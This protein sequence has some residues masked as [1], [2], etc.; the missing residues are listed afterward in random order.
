[1]ESVN[2]A[3]PAARA[4]RPILEE[5]LHRAHA[6]Y[7]RD[8]PLSLLS[9]KEACKYMPGGNT[10]TVLY[11]NPFP[12]SFS[13]GFGCL[14][15]TLDGQQYI[16]FLGDFSAGIYGHSHP[17]IRK[18]IDDALDRGWNMGGHNQLEHELAQVLC[19]RFPPLQMV[20]FVNSG[21]EAVMISI[22]T[23]IAF[24]KR[25]KVLL[26]HKGYRGSTIS[27]RF[28][29]GRQSINLPHEFVLAPY[30]D[31]V[32][33]K[34][35]IEDLPPDSL[36]AIVVEPMLGSGGCFVGKE[37]F[38]KY[39]R[40][41]SSKLGALLIFDEVMTS[42]LFYFD[43]GLTRPI[44]PD[45]MT[46]GEWVGG[47][48]PF[49]AFGGRRNIMA[50]YD[51]RTCQLEHSGTF[52]NNVLSM[53]A[54][55]AGC[56]LLT[57]E[58][59][60]ELNRNGALMTQEIDNL[61]KRYQVKGVKPIA[62]VEDE[63]MVI[64]EAPPKIF[65]TGAGSLMNIHFSGPEKDLLQALFWHHMLQNGIYLAER[66][67]IALSIELQ[68]AEIDLFVRAVESFCQTWQEYLANA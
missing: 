20:R 47:G 24:T 9:H 11:T 30:N 4:Y 19:K 14:L 10:S 59:L 38:L 8:H 39:L 17:V 1:M 51:P 43:M 45:M 64:A 36:A 46:L 26:F 29:A 66:G 12:L 61:L 27:G 22:A 5:A 58:R 7:I 18:A 42:R 48:M 57:K 16:D 35:I 21:T 40:Q 34:T 23:A 56:D 65:I 50:L 49:G 41:V 60:G 37:N 2:Q 13:S 63:A 54:G 67:F 25:S 6:Q 62:P 68:P 3:Q 32:R 55:I 31:I 33:T 52:N 44:I 28:S 53:S 15:F